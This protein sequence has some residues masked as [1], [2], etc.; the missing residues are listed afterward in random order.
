MKTYRE[1]K[2]SERTPPK[3]YK[4]ASERS[5]NVIVRYSD[6]IDEAYYDYGKKLWFFTYPE[7]EINSKYLMWWL[8]EIEQ[9]ICKSCEASSKLLAQLSDE[10]KKEIIENGEDVYIRVAKEK[11]E[12]IEQP[13]MSA[14]EFFNKEEPIHDI[15][16]IIPGHR[17]SKKRCIELMEKYLNLH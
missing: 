3:R 10:D 9:P 5:I 17:V 8:E 4:Q 15:N 12:E 7:E 16:T 6:I 11:I 14:E 2:V 13:K 1:V